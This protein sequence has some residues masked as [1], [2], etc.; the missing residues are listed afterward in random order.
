MIGEYTSIDKFPRGRAI[1]FF[2]G[3][4]W[5]LFQDKQF[6]P[7]AMSVQTIFSMSSNNLFLLLCIFKQ[8]FSVFFIPSYK[9]VRLHENKTEKF[10]FL[11]TSSS[12]FWLDKIVFF[13]SQIKT[14]VR[15]Q[16]LSLSKLKW[17]NLCQ[18]TSN[19]GGIFK[20]EYCG[21]G[22]IYFEHI[23]LKLCR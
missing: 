22:K 23:F 6:F 8:F 15:K 5:K 13:P 1:S 14:I 17:F 9:L 20:I 2:G 11:S 21:H 18:T 10:I 12:E 4:G 19:F 16:R 3:G 7:A